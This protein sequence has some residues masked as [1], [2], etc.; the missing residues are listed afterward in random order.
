MKKGPGKSWNLTSNFLWQP[1][2]TNLIT[3]DSS[4]SVSLAVSLSEL[5]T[6]FGFFCVNGYSSSS[7]LSSSAEEVELYSSLEFPDVSGSVSPPVPVSSGLRD[8]FGIIVEF[9]FGVN[10]TCGIS[11]V[12]SF[13]SRSDASCTAASPPSTRL[14]ITTA[15]FFEGCFNDTTSSAVP[16]YI[17]S[18]RCLSN[19]G[20]SHPRSISHASNT[21][22]GASHPVL[23][24]RWT[25]QRLGPLWL[26]QTNSPLCWLPAGKLFGRRRSRIF[27]TRCRNTASLIPNART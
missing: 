16:G 10:S 14:S 9:F 3:L 2:T 22:S 12:K 15:R 4:L 17:R 24:L 25:F 1:C 5:I 7:D 19:Q 13:S 21:V 27:R 8:S 26:G 18:N 23:N 11:I 6:F 20:R